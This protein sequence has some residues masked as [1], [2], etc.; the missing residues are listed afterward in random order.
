MVLGAVWGRDG[1]AGTRLAA[2]PRQENDA[3]FGADWIW[4]N[5]GGI[6]HLH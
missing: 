1:T 5:A 4:E 3:D 6:S 2:Y